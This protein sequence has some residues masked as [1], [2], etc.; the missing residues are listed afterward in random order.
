M[1]FRRPGA[2]RTALL[3]ILGTA[4]AAP[5]FAY[6]RREFYNGVRGLGMGDTS[7]ATVNDETAL[8]L[9]PAALGRLRDFYGTMIDPEIDASNRVPDLYRAKSISRPFTAS[10]VVP[11]LLQSLNQYY[12]LKMQIMPSFVARNFGIGLL[13]NYTFDGEAKSPTSVDVYSRDD[14]GLLLGYNARLWGGRIKLGVTGKVISRIEM[15]EVGLDPTTQA[16]D[17]PSLA[18]AGL[19]KE[20]VGVGADVGLL[21]TAPW[22]WLPTLGAVVRDVGNT[23][24]DK[25]SGLRL[26]DATERPAMS[27]QDLDVG[28][29]VSPIHRNNVRSMWTIEY[30]GLLTASDET[31]KAK[32]MHFGTEVNF[33]DV[34]FL[35][36]GYNQRYWTAG[37]ELASERFQMQI[38]SY[39]EEIGDATTPRED[40][41]TVLKLAL[42]F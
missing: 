19:L 14:L 12:H 22:T 20:G 13:G 17:N 40:R 26:K 15:N 24:Y 28:F 31:D 4:G 5:A 30:R 11:S 38:A 27:K 1:T 10:S 29:S 42:R 39:G 36:A 6:E 16:M 18:A 25:M 33:G 2:W 34:F 3:F 8:A 41:R 21:L 37:A 7:V 32:L 35:R 23:S 9:N